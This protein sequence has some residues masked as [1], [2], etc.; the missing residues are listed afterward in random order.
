[1]FFNGSLLFQSEENMIICEIMLNFLGLVTFSIQIFVMVLICT[2]ATFYQILNK[3]IF[4]MTTRRPLGSRISKIELNAWKHNHNL[5]SRFVHKISRCFG[6][7]IL[8]AVCHE[9]ISFIT[10]SYELGLAA[11]R[12]NICAISIYSGML[13]RELLF[14]SV[15]IWT[16]YTLEF[17]VIF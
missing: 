12:S 16:S 10:I 11:Q 15:Y 5:V 3:R 1:M 8:V 13:A 17:E 6:P 7:I 14:L 4:E 9:F 2:G